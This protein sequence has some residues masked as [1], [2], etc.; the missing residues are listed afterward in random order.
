MVAAGS[1]GPK[2]GMRR[3]QKYVRA[4]FDTVPSTPAWQY[5]EEQR[6]AGHGVAMGWDFDYDAGNLTAMQAVAARTAAAFLKSG[7]SAAAAKSIRFGRFSLNPDE[8]ILVAYESREGGVKAKKLLTQWVGTDGSV[9]PDNVARLEEM[10]K[11]CEVRHAREALRRQSGKST[12]D[13]RK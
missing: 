3:L 8:D 2:L 4:F 5:G 11:A 10:H 6:A 9:S 1:A 12:W 7:G 13:A